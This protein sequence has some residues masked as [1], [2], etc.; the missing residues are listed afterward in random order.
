MALIEV[1]TDASGQ[2]TLVNGTPRLTVDA[3][4][5][6][7]SGTFAGGSGYPG[8]VR[9]IVYAQTGAQSSGTATIPY[10]NTIPQQTEGWEVMTCSIT[11]QSSTSKLI[12]TA[13]LNC[14]SSFAGSSTVMM[15][16]FRD[17]TVN[18]IGV[19]FAQAPLQY[20]NVMLVAQ[21]SV[22]SG[23][24]SSTTFKMRMGGNA[25][26]TYSNG[27]QANGPVFNG[28]SA[29]SLMIMEVGA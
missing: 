7:V 15:A 9:Q 4:G 13:V 2:T 20:A 25:G 18:A 16:L 1:I 29:T 17:A 14:S 26:T 5:V 19:S 22:T 12:V 11:P 27:Q 10:D 24:T 23:S 8:G 3:T 6:T 21:V 28:T